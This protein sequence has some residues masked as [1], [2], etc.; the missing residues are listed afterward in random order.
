MNK[1]KEKCRNKSEKNKKLKEFD[2]RKIK[3]RKNSTVKKIWKLF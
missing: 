2:W 3:I 1:N